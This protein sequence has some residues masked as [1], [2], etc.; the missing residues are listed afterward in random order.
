MFLLSYLPFMPYLLF[1]NILSLPVFSEIFG[2]NLY[3]LVFLFLASVFG[4]LPRV[5]LLNINNLYII[6]FL[7]INFD[8]CKFAEFCTASK[9]VVSLH[10]EK[11]IKN[12]L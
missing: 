11:K 10:C 9:I 2:K 6:I 1:I 7:Y 4:V 8:I 12:V 3:G 5:N